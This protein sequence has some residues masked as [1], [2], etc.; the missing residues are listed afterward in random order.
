MSTPIYKILG[1][2][3]GAI[4]EHIMTNLDGDTFK[5]LGAY[6]FTKSMDQMRLLGASSRHPL[7]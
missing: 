5:I 4:R 6:V 3:G 2:Y 7:C 1:A